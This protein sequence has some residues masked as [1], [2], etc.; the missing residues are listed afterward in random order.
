MKKF[1]EITDTKNLH[2]WIF[3][4]GQLKLTCSNCGIYLILEKADGQKITIK[5][6]VTRRGNINYVYK[7][8]DHYEKAFLSVEEENCN[9]KILKNIKILKISSIERYYRFYCRILPVFTSRQKITRELRKRVLL[10]FWEFFLK[11]YLAYESITWRRFRDT[12]ES[13]SYDDFL[14]QLNSFYEKN[15]LKIQ[16]KLSTLKYKPKFVILIPSFSQNDSSDLERTLKSLENQIYKNYEVLMLSGD[17]AFDYDKGDCFC[18]IYPGDTLTEYALYCVANFLNI[19]KQKPDIIY[20][21]HDIM[22]SDGRKK[23]PKFK[24]DWSKEYFLSYDYIENLFLFEREI[25]K[26]IEGFNLSSKS[27][28]TY[29]AIL[30]AIKNSGEL[31]IKHIP[32][33]LYNQSE[34]NHKKKQND[35]ELGFMALKQFCSGVEDIEKL[36]K[37]HKPGIL[38]ILYRIPNPNPSV[39]IITPTRNN[40]EVLKKCFSSILEKTDYQ[41]YEIIII[42]NNSTEQNCLQYYEKLKKIEKIKVFNYPTEFNF[43]KLV[44]FGVS[45]ARGDFICLLNDDTEVINKEWLSELIRYG[46]KEGIGAVGCKLLYPDGK[47]QHAGVVV[48]IWNGAAHAFRGL[49]N[50]EEGYMFRCIVPCEVLAVTAACMLVKKEFYNLVN[51]FDE[52]FQVAF[53][54]VDFCL[55]LISKG[56]RNIY[57][58]YTLVYHYEGFSRGMNNKLNKISDEDL[59]YFR[60]KWNNFLK[61]DQYYN[62]NL[63]LHKE[64]FCLGNPYTRFLS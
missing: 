33:V 49:K 5:L 15:K 61:R 17:K 46:T 53:N 42:N 40:Y 19:S 6:P 57:V 7:L 11:P 54:D 34:S 39:S 10:S 1:F 4:K 48:G 28:C 62:P 30:K 45:K 63:T 8:S 26:K 38:K 60:K 37:T 23:E 50:S 24:P 44:N 14:Y 64:D 21:D 16:K 41:N 32:M 18:L 55:K 51:G 56:Y 29:E 47:I 27:Y 12:C 13:L 43:S 22:D 58:P 25:F 2:S 20:T 9:V 52:N 59:L 36:E 35:Y 3:I 31:N